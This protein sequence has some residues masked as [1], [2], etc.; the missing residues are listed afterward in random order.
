M[1]SCGFERTFVP[2]P[3][4]HRGVK[5]VIVD[6]LVRDR[7]AAPAA[8]LLGFLQCDNVGIDLMQHVEH[9]MWIPLMYPTANTAHTDDFAGFVPSLIGKPDFLTMYQQS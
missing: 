4:M 6:Q 2:H 3:Q 8:A 1:L 5:A 7:R 9:A